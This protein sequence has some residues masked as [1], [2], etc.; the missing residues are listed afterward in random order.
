GMLG[1]YL[2]RLLSSLDVIKEERKLV[3]LGPGPAVVYEYGGLES[4]R[5]AYSS[6]LAWMPGLV[7]MAKN[8]YVWLD[9]LSKKYQR[10]IARLNEIP[11]DELDVLARWGFTGLWLI[12]LWERSPASQRIK[13][14]C[15]NPD[16]VPSAYSLYDYV[17]AADLGGES[18]YEDLKRR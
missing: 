2:Y 7:L 10:P 16:A 8:A 3:F 4:Q 9:Q 17:I 6:E 14:L 18:A 1:K 11:D 15:G 12:G 13:Q 5:A